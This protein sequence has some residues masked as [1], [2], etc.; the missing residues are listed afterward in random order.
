MFA[1]FAVENWGNDGAICPHL[2]TRQ[3]IVTD[4]C[5]VLKHFQTV[6]IP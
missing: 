4:G 3:A 1:I 6:I 2:A 5:V